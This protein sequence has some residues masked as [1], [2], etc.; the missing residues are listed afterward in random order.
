MIST[1]VL[2]FHVAQ[3]NLINKENL[4]NKYQ[5][6]VKIFERTKRIHENVFVNE[7]ISFFNFVPRTVREQTISN[8][9]NS[10]ANEFKD[11]G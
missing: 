7:R 6:F 11:T 9:F 4:I 1:Y 3:K 5:V 10:V 2:C 8:K